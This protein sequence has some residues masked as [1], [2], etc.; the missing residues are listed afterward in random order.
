MLSSAMATKVAAA[1]RMAA[2]ETLSAGVEALGGMSAAT[3]MKAPGA[4]A[5]HT[6]RLVPATKQME[7]T[8]VRLLSGGVRKLPAREILAS[9]IAVRSPSEPAA[10]ECGVRRS[11]LGRRTSAGHPNPSTAPF[12]IPI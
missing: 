1:V 10:I 6:L 12:R 2:A 3:H 9:E 11:I 7:A 5:G 4:P 8:R